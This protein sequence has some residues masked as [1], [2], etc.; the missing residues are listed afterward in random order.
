M[1]KKEKMKSPADFKQR[2][3]SKSE[4]LPKSSH[5]GVTVST[6]ANRQQSFKTDLG[7]ESGAGGERVKVVVRIRPMNEME[8]KREDQYTIEANDDK[9][10]QCNE[11]NKLFQFNAALNE[12]NLQEDVFNK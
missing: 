1:Q 5:S 10:I 7:M 2:G 11:A 8:L 12:D 4:L 9:H 6:H 3:K